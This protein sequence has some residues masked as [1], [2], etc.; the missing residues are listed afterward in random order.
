VVA[1]SQPSDGDGVSEEFQS[2]GMEF[3]PSRDEDPVSAGLVVL[4]LLTDVCF[5]RSSG[6]ILMHLGRKR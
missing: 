4:R 1:A 3:H 2:H 5:P 6:C